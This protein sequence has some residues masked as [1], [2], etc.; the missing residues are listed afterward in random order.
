MR[1]RNRQSTRTH[2]RAIRTSAAH[3]PVIAVTW[4]IHL[5]AAVALYAHEMARVALDQPQ[6]LLFCAWRGFG[7]VAAALATVPT[8]RSST[9]RR[10]RFRIATIAVKDVVE[11]ELALCL[12]LRRLGRVEC[13]VTVDGRELGE[14]DVRVVRFV[15]R[16]LVHSIPVGFF[17]REG[18]D[19]VG[20]SFGRNGWQ[21]C[22]ANARRAG[23][24]RV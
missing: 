21:V 11:G 4:R 20:C 9:T 22:H 19:V 5:V 12:M 3:A 18:V 8:D 1:V 7:P 14:L 17:V 2:A 24:T 15:R 23:A 16:V 10:A 13:I 6:S